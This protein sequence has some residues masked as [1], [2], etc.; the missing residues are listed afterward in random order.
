MCFY[1]Q[2]CVWTEADFLNLHA[3][4]LCVVRE[5]DGFKITTSFHLLLNIHEQSAIEDDCSISIELQTD[6]CLGADGL[7]IDLCDSQ[8]G[9]PVT[10]LESVKKIQLSVVLT[11]V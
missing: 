6:K 7:S 3:C 2:Q 9:I 5:P 11:L 4:C 10:R 1:V 8:N